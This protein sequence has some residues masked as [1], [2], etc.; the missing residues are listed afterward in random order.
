[1]GRPDPIAG[2]PRNPRRVLWMSLGLAAQPPGV[3]ACSCSRLPSWL[4]Q[5]LKMKIKASLRNLRT[6]HGRASCGRI[7]SLPSGGSWPSSGSLGT[8]REDA[9]GTVSVTLQVRGSAR[10]SQLHRA[11]GYPAS[12]RHVSVM[13]RRGRDVRPDQWA[14]ALSFHLAPIHAKAPPQVIW[15]RTHGA[16]TWWEYTSFANGPFAT[17]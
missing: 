4:R 8:A 11:A 1:M 15:H 12:V 3:G 16:E 5:V 7:S 6:N 9:S 10:I 13:G 17:R 14:I 2:P